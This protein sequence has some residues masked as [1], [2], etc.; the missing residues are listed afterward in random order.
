MYLV[1]APQGRRALGT[2]PEVA[3]HLGHYRMDRARMPAAIV[4][5]HSG[6]RRAAQLDADF[7]RIISRSA[8]AASQLPPLLKDA[9]GPFS[10]PHQ[11]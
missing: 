11:W 2:L 8:L 9:A 1:P 6:P 5:P 7:F 10:K 3:V 4:N